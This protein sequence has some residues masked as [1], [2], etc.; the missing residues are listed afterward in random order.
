MPPPMISSIRRPASMPLPREPE[1][2]EP[3]GAPLP[4]RASGGH[5]RDTTPSRFTRPWK[6]AAPTC[7]ATSAISTKAQVTCTAW[8]AFDSGSFFAMNGGMPRAR[9]TSVG[10]SPASTKT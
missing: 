9:S 4:P 2:I 6:A 3:R 1:A 5:I 8:A 10:K 7:I